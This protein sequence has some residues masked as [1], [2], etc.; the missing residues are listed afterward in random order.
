[1]HKTTKRRT[2]THLIKLLIASWVSAMPYKALN[3]LWMEPNVHHLTL[4]T[5]FH[6]Y[7]LHICHYTHNKK[8]LNYYYVKYTMANKHMQ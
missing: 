5:V 4:V 8:S 2:K 6:Q 7:M 3:A 1:M